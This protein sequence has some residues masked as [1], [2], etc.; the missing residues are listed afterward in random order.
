MCC[1]RL[2]PRT[3]SAREALSA[4]FSVGVTVELAS[5]KGA[6]VVN[7][8][9]FDDVV[10]PRP[11]VDPGFGYLKVAGGDLPLEELWLRADIAGLAASVDLC[12]TFY[13]DGFSPLE[14]VYVF[15][16]PELGS[17]SSLQIR[18]GATVIDGWLLE[19]AEARDKYAASLLHRDKAAILEQEREDVVTIRVGTIAPGERVSVRL[20]LCMRLSYSD[21]EIFFRF[22]LVVAPRYIPG[23]P[24][25]GGQVGAGT[26][27]DTHLVP[28]AS[29]VSPPV[30][31]GSEARLSVSMNLAADAYTIDEIGCTLRSRITGSETDKSLRIE[32]LPGQHLDRDLVLRIR[33][34][35]HRQPS[36]SLLL[37]SPDGDG[38]E[39]T[40]ALT[41]LPPTIDQLTGRARDV[42][43]VVDTSA[44]MS[45]WRLSA[46][47][48]SAAKIIDSLAPS[49]RFSMLLS[50]DA[51]IDPGWAMAGLV[52]AT[53]R[54][55]FR[56]IEHLVGTPARGNPRLLPALET[57]SRLLNDP[58]RPSILVVIT[59]GHVGNEDQIAATFT[60]RSGAVR[61]HAIGIGAT[62]NTGLL[63][64]LAAVGRGEMLLAE[65][66]DVLEDLTPNLRRLL[67]PAFLTNLSLAGDG[68]QLLTNTISPS[69][70]P[71]IFSGIAVV[72]TGRF[73]G[74]WNGSVTVSGTGI[75]GRPWASRV[76]AVPVGGGALTQLWARA[77]LADLQHRYL[78]CPIEEAT[79]LERLI[80]TTSLQFGVLTRLTAF[81][82]ISNAPTRAPGAP[83][84]VIQSV[85]MPADWTE[86]GPSLSPYAIEY[87]RILAS[88]SKPSPGQ[89][90]SQPIR[91]PEAARPTAL[92]TGSA[93]LPAPP[94]ATPTSSA[95]FPAPP[96][97]FPRGPAGPMP[98]APPPETQSRR[99][100]YI[101]VGAAAVAVAAGITVFGVT[102]SQSQLR[103]ASPPP[104]HA[105][106]TP[107]ATETPSPPRRYATA[108]DPRTGVRL[109]VTVTPQRSGSQV[110]AHVAGIPVGR[111]ARLVVVGRDGSRHQIAEW[112]TDESAPVRSATTTL[113]ADEIG[114]VAI[115]DASGQTY[116]LASLQ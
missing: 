19:R 79:G 45:G 101:G 1:V 85:E 81:V 9:V 36:L 76:N 71:D 55:R 16:L 48:R 37:T 99:G 60:P 10:A 113:G 109:D 102:T 96:S 98:T 77:F 57:A 31:P 94:A 58:G 115:E 61:V 83:R 22:P 82:A 38:Q 26:A 64:R 32:A 67:G 104:T 111:N 75:D 110:T 2:A 112:V 49:D 84:Q 17:V 69:R 8:P 14:A 90:A 62:V 35:A 51:V 95:P 93:P 44:S 52:P 88:A 25:A 3:G 40:F 116:V 23:D 59:G 46:A 4:V 53:E 33:T 24:I 107:T 114:S 42:V 5:G 50:A 28:D 7:A 70:P 20:T 89:A 43:V 73:R 34:T 15:P 11:S 6:A 78:R 105:S 63:R 39:G 30:Q 13:N 86:P 65:T 100:R 29:R 66:E 18:T 80:V 91:D 97:N 106:Q 72:I 56:A 68:I 12:A 103:T 92:S 41:V 47:R 27:A 21:G 87:A 54:N 108:V 74:R